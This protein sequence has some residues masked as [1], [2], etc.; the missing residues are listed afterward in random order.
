MMD[1]NIFIVVDINSTEWWWSTSFNS[2][3]KKNQRGLSDAIL[4]LAFSVSL[5]NQV[6][7]M[8][9]I[10]LPTDSPAAEN[11]NRGSYSATEITTLVAVAYTSC[12]VLLTDAQR[13]SVSIFM[14]RLK[15]RSCCKSEGAIRKPGLER[16]SYEPYL[17]GMWLRTRFRALGRREFRGRNLSVMWNPIWL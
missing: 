9:G 11:A 17:P 7:D 14:M 15:L 8:K 5:V 6:S 13:T 2:K 4:R 1:L 3:H 16:L 10:E 12:M